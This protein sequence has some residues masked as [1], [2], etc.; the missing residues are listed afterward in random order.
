MSSSPPSSSPS[1]PWLTE[2][3]PL[4]RCDETQQIP[5]QFALVVS[6]PSKNWRMSEE[7]SVLTAFYRTIT[8]IMF[9]PSIRKRY[10]GS[11]RAYSSRR[12]YKQPD[13]GSGIS[14]KSEAA[15]NRSGAKL[16]LKVAHTWIVSS[17]SVHI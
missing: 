13:S 1:Q 2:L 6:D 5:L 7:V 17:S 12:L 16:K 9:I 10:Q 11:W 14:P 3:Q 15:R 8:R 4:L